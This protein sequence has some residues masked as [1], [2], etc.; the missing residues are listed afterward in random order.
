MESAFLRYWKHV[1]IHAD[2]W[3]ED[4]QEVMRTPQA[5]TTYLRLQERTRN[6][7]PFTSYQAML[8]QLWNDRI[9]A[10]DEGASRGLLATKIADKMANEESLWLAAA[11]FDQQSDDIAA[12]QAIGVLAIQEGSIGFSH[13]TV[14]E[15]ALSR[16]FARDNG[17]LSNYVLERQVSLFLRPKLWAGLN[18]L[19]AVEINAYHIELDAIWSAVDL[20]RHLRLLLID[21]LGHQTQP[22]DR[23]AL[24]MEHALGLP[25]DRWPAYRALSGSP[26]WFERFGHTFVAESMSDDDE[27]ADQMTEVLSRAWGFAPDDVTRLIQERWAP[28]R[29]HD[30]RSWRVLQNASRWTDDTL[31]VACTIVKRTEIAPIAIDHVVATIGVE[32]PE[33]ALRLARARLDHEQ[34]AYAQEEWFFRRD[35]LQN[36]GE[37]ESLPAL[38][39]QAPAKFLEILWPWFE[40]YFDALRTRTADRR[41]R[42]GYPLSYHAD[43]RFEQE[44]STDLQ[45]P[46]LLHGLRAAAES[47]ARTDSYAWLVWVERLEP[48]DIAPAQ[49]LIAHG[50]AIQPE[51]YAKPA[52]AFL[53][54]DPRRYVLGSTQGHTGTS[55]RLVEAVSSRW[56][57]EEI[58]RFET[59]VNSYNPPV[60]A[61]LIEA[62]GRREWNRIVRQIKLSLLSVLPKSRLTATTRRHVE[63][64]ERVFPDHELGVRSTRAQYIGSIMDVSAIVQASDEDVINAFR[65]LPD[66]TEWNHPRRLMEG[67]NI[68]LSREFANFAK[69]NPERA[70]RLLGLLEPETGTRAAGYT[71]DAMSQNGAPNQVLHLFHD[72]VRRGFDSEEFRIRASCALRRLVNRDVAVGEETISIME[73]WLANPKADG[74]NPDTDTDP[75]NQAANAEPRDL[76]DSV[77]RSLIWGI[78]GSSVVPS[79]EYPIVEALIGIRLRRKEHDHVDKVLCAY[80]DRRKSRKE[81][82][83][84]LPFVHF[85]YPSEPARRAE[86]LER[87]FSEIPALVGSIEAARVLVNAHWWHA[88]FANSQL[89][90]WRES[91][92]RLARQA[93][94]EIVAVAFLMQPE[95]A[96]AQTRLTA[97][98]ETK[99]LD[100]ARTGA[101][102]SAANLWSDADR[103]TS[104]SS[105]LTSLLD[106]GGAGVW[107]A[108]FESF[109]LADELMPD[110]AT[111]SL[112]SMIADRLVEAPH[113]D[114]RF[115]VECLATLL[116]NKAVL[117]GRVAKGLVGA[118]RGELADIRK[119]AAIAAR[120]LVDLAVTLHRL[121][122]E[123]REVGTD[124]F[125]QLIDIN[126][127]EARQTL[128]EID[129]RFREQPPVR[130]RRLARRAR[131]RSSTRG[132]ISPY[133]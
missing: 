92:R 81:W 118:W 76:E 84:L 121:G 61:D 102:L 55:L 14:F 47:L 3:P 131:A 1:D 32:Q 16:S 99:T 58:A 15:Y 41:E 109:R 49:R 129:N 120:P 39:E 111:E 56:S 10:V 91:E 115:V 40:Q 51:R 28:H 79:G 45:A 127:F 70:I 18:Y 116:P 94:G 21:F 90:L 71:L 43:F 34:S 38:A 13:Q 86:F 36:G 12:L 82:D 97:L 103:R 126:V 78:E 33:A 72:A 23:E 74:A 98:L 80:L 2:G 123:T 106:G 25:K 100:D 89:D 114:G 7:E 66:A 130:R 62:R 132:G 64:E 87:L 6:S 17:R 128:D 26:G 63:E 125:E 53:L 4:A 68:Q 29:R 37:W 95:L 105:L 5:L 22:T 117:I 19:R 113:L 133:A 54:D 44:Q 88:D 96:W 60:P 11:R 31:A 110:S 48:V 35:P 112:L 85:A 24:L 20:R 50:F 65:T 101:A 104:A 57:D 119:G 77:E 75:E 83:H 69:D 27:A 8:N 42:L 52:L 93:Y 67:G 73:D 46:A 108:T 122:P 59:A 124:L 9:L 30:E 107:L